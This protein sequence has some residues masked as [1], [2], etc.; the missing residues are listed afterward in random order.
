[1]EVHIGHCVPYPDVC[2]TRYGSHGKAAETIVMHHEHFIRFLEFVRDSKDKVGF[3]NIELNFLNALKNKETLTELCVL[4]LY[5]ATVLRPFMQHV[6]L[7]EK[8]LGLGPFFQKKVEF[9]ESISRNP[10]IWT[11]NNL[12]DNKAT[13]GGNGWDE[14]GLNVVNAVRKFT[15]DL[16]NLDKAVAAFVNGA[17]TT[18]SERFSDEFKAGGDIDTLTDTERSALYFASTN[19]INEGSLGRWRLGQHRHPAETLHKFNAAFTTGQNDTEEFI[20][21]KLTEKSGQDYLIKTARMRDESGMQ[22]KLKEEQM[23]A[24]AEKV[25]K[26]RKKE[27]KRQDKRD[28]RAATITETSKNLKLTDAEIENLNVEELNRQLDYHREEENKLPRAVIEVMERVPLK[29]HMKYKAMRISEL[30]KAVARY[31]SRVHNFSLYE[32]PV[33]TGDVSTFSMAGPEEDLFY[34]SDCHDDLT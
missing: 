21:H 22:M 2:N 4:A 13:L 31:L 32:A 27:A 18:F 7:H 20:K 15:A 29:S 34:E 19:D 26:N 28:Q 10:K 6:H 30:K 23:R 16:P 11:G 14:W 9:L 5:N 1:M 3:T 12:S 33:S 8:L 17:K 25:S 24:D